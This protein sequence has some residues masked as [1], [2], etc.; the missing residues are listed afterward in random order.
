MHT[1]KQRSNTRRFLWQDLKPNPMDP[2]VR[3]HNSNVNQISQIST[4]KW[5]NVPVCIVETV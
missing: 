4:R 1:S 3:Q 5:N 2:Q